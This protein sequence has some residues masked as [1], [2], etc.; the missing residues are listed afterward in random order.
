MVFVISNLLISQI[1]KNFCH[2]AGFISDTN[3][4]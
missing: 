2:V 3:F 1:Q 4:R